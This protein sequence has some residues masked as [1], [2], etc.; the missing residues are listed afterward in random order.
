MEQGM[1]KRTRLAHSAM[2]KAKVALTAMAGDKFTPTCCGASPSS[3]SIRFG[4]W[5]RPTFQWPKGLF[6]SPLLWIGPVAKVLAAK[7]AITLEACHAVDVLQEAFTHHGTPEIVNTVGA[8][9][10]LRMSSCRPSRIMDAKSA[11]TDEEP[12]EIMCSLSVCGS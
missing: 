7:V 6:T 11:W 9:N 1:A 4:R 2:F 10:S 3:G 5:T 8:V 12:G